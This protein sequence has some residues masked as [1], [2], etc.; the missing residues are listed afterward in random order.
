MSRPLT[1]RRC[2]VAEMSFSCQPDNFGQRIVA[3]TVR[4][5]LMML[6]CWLTPVSASALDTTQARVEALPNAGLSVGQASSYATGILVVF[7]LLTVLVVL[8]RWMQSRVGRRPGAMSVDASLALGGKERLL[9]V[10]V[11]GQRLLIGVAPGG[12][13]LITE[14]GEQTAQVTTSGSNNWLRD[15]LAQR[16]QR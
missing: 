11:E 13:Q 10:N 12:V 1:Q 3:F 14:L 8:A 16:G 6:G 9:V 4:P 15:T 2:L 5:R 7:L